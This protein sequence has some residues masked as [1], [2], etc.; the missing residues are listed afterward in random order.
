MKNAYAE[1]CVNTT[2]Q[3]DQEI[4]QTLRDMHCLLQLSPEEIQAAMAGFNLKKYKKGTLL[5]REGQVASACYS[6]FKGCVR[7]YYLLGNQEKTSEFYLAGDSLSDDWSKNQRVP[8]KKYWECLEDSTVSVVGYEYEQELFRRFPR[9]ESLC[10][11]ETEKQFG[12]YRD[13]MALFLASTPEERYLQVL[14]T[15]PYLLERVP[16]YHLASYIGVK[17]ESL[18]RIRG[19]LQGLR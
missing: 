12:M 8:S 15:R 13:K 4:V 11:I 19:R 14:Q 3:L 9:L 7:E 16:Q 1:S 18:S 2:P 5:L 17:P 6:I 10:R